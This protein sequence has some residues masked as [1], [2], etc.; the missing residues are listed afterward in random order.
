MKTK[1]FSI[2]GALFLLT[3]TSCRKDFRDPDLSGLDLADDDAVSEAVYD[4][5]FNSVDNATIILDES[6]KSGDN[7]ATIL[8]DD[9]CP[10]ITVEHPSA[11]IWPKIIT[12]DYGTGCTGLFDNT[13]SGKMIIEVTGPRK[14]AGSK[15]TV[16]F[17][18]YYFNNI[19]VEGEKVLENTG[20][21]ENQNFVILVKLTDGKLTM[22]DGATIERTV[23]HQ[24]E[25]IAGFDSKN[26]WDDECLISGVTSGINLKGYEYTRTITTALYWKRVCKFIVSG[27]VKI[28]REGSESV[29]LDYGSGGCDN[30]AILTF[31]GVTKEINLRHRY[32]TM[33]N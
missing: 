30:K 21:N 7:K 15:R 8:S 27:V 24:R 1:A 19:K 33:G 13:R 11:G 32:R 29:E 20:L 26:I 10:V 14:E 22:P 25:W 23:D 16:T 31:G 3:V 4:D 5:V 17:D 2:I 9:S 18:N 12:L 6:M 28:E